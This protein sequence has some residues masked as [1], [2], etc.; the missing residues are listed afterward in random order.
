MMK[1]LC[2][3]AV[4]S[5]SLLCLGSQARANDLSGR[6]AGLADSERRASPRVLFM[7]AEQNIGQEL[8][9]FWWSWFG[10][11]G[12]QFVGQTVDMAVSESVLKDAFLGQGFDVI[13]ISTKTGTIEVSNA[14]RVADLTTTAVRSYGNKFEADIVVTGKALAKEGPRTPGSSVGSYLADITLSAIRVD[15]GQVLAS[16]RGHGVARH[17]AQHSGGNEALARAAQGVTDK[18][19]S[20]IMSKWSAR[21]A[22][23]F[24]R[25]SGVGHSDKSPV[26]GDSGLPDKTTGIR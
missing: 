22:S 8:A 21:P 11:G 5:I 15:T 16:T 3:F 25:S 26:G 19:I 17:V 18:F 7:V 9:I 1:R 6:D 4:L 10:Q 23:G 20:Q 2:A 24:E 14:Y 13:D 12:S